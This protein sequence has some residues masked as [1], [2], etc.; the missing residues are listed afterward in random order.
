MKKKLPILLFACLLSASCSALRMGD[1]ASTRHMPFE[2]VK[3][4]PEPT[5]IIR[6]NPLLSDKE[7]AKEWYLTISAHDK[8]LQDYIH[9]LVK[10]MRVGT[11]QQCNIEEILKEVN[12]PVLPNIAG[13]NSSEQINII[14]ARSV[15]DIYDSY[16][17]LI[18]SLKDCK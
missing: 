11:K 5:D 17:E 18:A 14:L 1:K 10:D 16:L 2:N 7:W 9:I 13:V 4:Q 15:R 8:Y 3:E 12:E 6:N